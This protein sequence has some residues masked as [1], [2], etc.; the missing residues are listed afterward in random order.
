MPRGVIL[1]ARLIAL[2]WVA[3]LCVFSA[4]LIGMRGPSINTNILALLPQTDRDPVVFAAVDR[5]ARHFERHL[6]VVVGAPD[7]ETAKRAA[8]LA[9]ER[10][11]ASGQFQRLRVNDYRDLVRNAVTFYLPQRFH[12]LGK[13]ARSR[14]L[15]EDEAG[16]ERAILKQYFA[17]QSALTSDL[18]DRDPLM[19]LPAFLRER[20]DAASGRPEI[21]DGYLTVQTSDRI[22]IA[23]VGELSG[24][25]FSVGVQ[26]TL[27]PLLSDLRDKLPEEAAGS[28]FMVAGVLPHAAAG[29]QSGIDEMSTV[30]IC[31]GDCHPSGGD[32]SLGPAVLSDPDGNRSRMYQRFCGMS[33]G[34]R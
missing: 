4:T 17:P 27:V 16:F 6:A 1:R 26:R 15:G 5:V 33:C 21:R 9:A 23:L 8:G 24:S 34:L 13:A 29:T 22:Y 14:L 25:P 18:I 12:L 7:F 2:L 19:L 28:D 11:L 32:V 10:L 3:A 30:G 20:A 31:A